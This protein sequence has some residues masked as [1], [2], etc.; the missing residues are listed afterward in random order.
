VRN[1]ILTKLKIN[2]TFTNKD[3]AHIIKAASYEVQKKTNE[4]GRRK[5]IGIPEG[6]TLYEAHSGSET[7]NI[8]PNTGNS[9]GVA[10]V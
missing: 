7:N 9:N 5:T 1:I 4:T 10:Q 8:Q 2:I 6:Y 3:L